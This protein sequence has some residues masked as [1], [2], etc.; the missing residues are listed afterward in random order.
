MS[1]TSLI[2]ACEAFAEA[3][4]RLVDAARVEDADAYDMATIDVDRLAKHIAGEVPTTMSGIRAKARAAVLLWAGPG[5]D[6]PGDNNE[7][8]T[9]VRS[10]VLDLAE[11]PDSASVVQ[12]RGGRGPVAI[13]GRRD[14]R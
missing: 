9:L 10:L 14:W 7:M 11:M 5:S 12:F 6:L 4:Q 3:Y 2:L 1:D 8:T 13:G